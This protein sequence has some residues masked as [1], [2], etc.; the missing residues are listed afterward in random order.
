MCCSTWLVTFRKY[1]VVAS[2]PESPRTT[3]LVQLLDQYRAGHAPAAE[4]LA[5]QVFAR[6]QQLAGQ[7][8]KGFPRLQE[9][10]T[11]DDLFQGA[12]V[13]LL[14]ALQEVR[15]DSVRHFHNLAAVQLRRELLDLARRYKNPITAAQET[16]IDIA[17]PDTL[18]RWIDLHE[19]VAELAGDDRDLVN[20][21]IYMG[22]SQ[23]EVA[24][25][26]G[27]SAKTVQRRWQS[28]CLLLYDRLGGVL[29]D[30]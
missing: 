3:Q 15:V 24:A 23:Q 18:G 30:S 20:D 12:M 27:V 14:K 7:M 5:Q 16:L 26:L 6:L 25:Q 19:A 1:A 11:A 13:R 22:L 4:Q 9:H 21:L 29:P 17:S 8:L 2:A 10:T 28:I